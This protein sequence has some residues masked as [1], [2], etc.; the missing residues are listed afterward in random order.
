MLFKLVLLLLNFCQ[1]YKNL[2]K[3]VKGRCLC[4]NY[5]K[6]ISLLECLWSLPWGPVHLVWWHSFIGDPCLF[7]KADWPSKR[8]VFIQGLFLIS[9]WKFPTLSFCPDYSWWLTMFGCISQLK[10]FLQPQVVLRQ[11]ILSQL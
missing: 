7:K 2:D 11:I 4:K 3:F 6:V 5:V 1:L 8:V 10:S 9:C